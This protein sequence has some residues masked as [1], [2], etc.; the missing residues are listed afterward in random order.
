[1]APGPAPEATRLE[2]F[3]Q[4]PSPGRALALWFH[5]LTRPPA[6]WSRR[7]VAQQLTREIARIDALL[8]RQV[9]VILHHPAVQRLE[10]S[11]RGLRYLVD[12][13]PE[14]ENIKIRVLNVS[15]KELARDL[16]RAL[17]FDQ[18][19]LFHKVYG[20]EFGMPGGEPFGILL[21]DYEVRP[22]PGPEHPFDDVG[23]LLRL[24][25][26]AAAAFAP[27]VAGLH[28]SFLGLDSFTELERRLDLPRTFEGTE[29]LKWR[30]FRQ[31]EDAR[32]VGLALPRVLMRLPYPDVATRT[33]GFRFR[34]EVQKPDR[35]QYLWGTA[36][37]AFA[38]VVVRAFV[39]SRWLADIRGVQGG[40]AAGGLVTGLPVPSF[41]TDAPGVAP[42]SST[43]ALITD[44]RERE[45]GEL[46]FIPLCH[47]P[48]TSLAAFYGNQSV[49]RAQRYDRPTATANARLSAML[50]YV[51]C[52]SRIAHY[53]K[54][55]ARDKVGSF[56]GPEDCEEYLRRWALSYTVARDDVDP[57]TKARYPLRD[58]NVQIREHPDKPG[59]YL[60][61]FHLQPHFQLDQVVTAVR[62]VTELTPGQRR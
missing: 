59:S 36:V 40:A 8:S 42:R 44:M 51:L 2:Q 53:L 27:I 31:T 13:V 4:E 48:D 14:A 7:E 19:Q 21:G 24:S 37:Y 43:D 38:A 49:Q 28:P 54:V 46:G 5:G 34:E 50:Q 33:D 11:W 41:R 26:V 58:A 30:A 12:Q 18:S 39:D 55:L 32:F 52:V 16:E 47:C 10:A 57:E 23:V 29:Y 22:R 35:S 3:L 25:A 20:E 6:G 1:M 15:W 62:L 56:A 9:N 61:V 45:L 60:G 17:E